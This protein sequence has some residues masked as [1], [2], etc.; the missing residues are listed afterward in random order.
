VGTWIFT[1][2]SDSGDRGA[3]R[4]SPTQE[5]VPSAEKRLFGTG[6]C[7]DPAWAFWAGVL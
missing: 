7:G 6:A 5:K 1:L 2:R 4:S 3:L